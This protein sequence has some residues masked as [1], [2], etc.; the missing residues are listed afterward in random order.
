[1]KNLAQLEKQQ[2]TREETTHL[3]LWISR[4]KVKLRMG[5]LRQ[6][7]IETFP[8]GKAEVRISFP[9]RNLPPASYGK[10][11]KSIYTIGVANQA[12]Q[13]RNI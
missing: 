7:S 8:L 12:L 5:R 6:K 3:I 11:L 1:M 10:N 2:I 4:T 13:K 9:S